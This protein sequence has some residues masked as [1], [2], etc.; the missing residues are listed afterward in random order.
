VKKIPAADAA[1]EIACVDSVAVKITPQ[2]REEELTCR[3][4]VFQGLV[5]V[6]S[7]INSIT[8]YDA[9]LEAVIEVSRD[10]FQSE[11]SSL[12]LP[13]PGGEYL[14]LAVAANRETMEKPRILVPRGRGIAWWV[15]ENRE[16]QLIKDAYA[17]PRFYQEADRKTGFRTRSI[18]SAPLI[19]EN[20]TV[21]VL[22]L[23]NPIH[24]TTF[25]EADLEAIQGYSSL[26]ATALEKMRIIEERQKA[27]LLNRDLAIAAE[28][29]QGQLN[30]AV[31]PALGDRVFVQTRPA[32]EVGGDFYFLRKRQNGDVWFAVGDVSGKGIAASMLMSQTM[33]ALRFLLRGMAGPAAI[34]SRL[35]RVIHEVSVRGMFVTI[36]LGRYQ[37]PGRLEI[38]TAGHCFPWILGGSSNPHEWQIKSGLPLGILEDV[39]YYQAERE[40]Q[41]KELLLLF[42]DGLSESRGVGENVDFSARLPEILQRGPQ[43]AAKLGPYLLAEEAAHRGTAPQRDDLT[44]LLMEKP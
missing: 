6:S 40:W 30:R 32:Y 21:A 33:G 1:V 37:N 15:F 26:L 5:R 19:Y 11:A 34:L 24:K 20:R 3:L 29:Q 13:A 16:P 14:E 7:L 2:N 31:D 17:D 18:L 38:A 10:V 8:D 23:I 9:M 25:D 39:T 44:L 4:A 36:A 27:Q 22:Q 41:D 42:S 35:N 12:F 43:T 28:I